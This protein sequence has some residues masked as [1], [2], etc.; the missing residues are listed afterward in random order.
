MTKQTVY[1]AHEWYRFARNLARGTWQLEVL[2]GRSRFSG[3]DLRGKA[4][5]FKGSYMRSRDNL[6]ERMSRAGIPYRIEGGGSRD[7]LH[8]EFF[9]APISR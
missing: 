2:S 3:A 5:R 7:P 1:S 8:V 4:A 9:D 6:L